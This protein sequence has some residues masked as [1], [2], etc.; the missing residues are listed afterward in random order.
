MRRHLASAPLPLLL[1][2][3]CAR[4]GAQALSFQLAP[5]Q[6]R[7]IFEQIP[8]RTL[9]TGDWQIGFDAS[10]V[11]E[12][13]KVEIRGPDDA[14]LFKKTAHDNGHFAV[15]ARREGVHK[16][17]VTNGADVGRSATLNLKTALEVADHDTVAKKEHV[18]AIEAELDRM[19]KMAVHVYEEMLCVPARSR[20]PYLARHGPP[21]P[22]PRL[23]C[24][25]TRGPCVRVSLPPPHPDRYMR[26][27]S[28]QQHATNA[29]TRGR[30]LWVEVVMMLVVLAM[31]LWQIRYLRNYF[32]Q[33]KV[34]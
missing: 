19:K 31:G 5:S 27:R 18:E 1:L 2:L 26:T 21:P 3:A 16:V 14:V 8:A 25:L 12:T 6:E 33:K 9:L 10:S 29:S 30:L 7:C 13:D 24:S 34:I 4:L 15:T 20:T 28:D 22:W 32:K 23:S 17:C 11:N